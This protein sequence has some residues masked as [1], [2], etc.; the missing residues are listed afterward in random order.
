MRNRTGWLI[1]AVAALAGIALFAQSMQKKM[2]MN[3]MPYAKVKAAL[4]NPATRMKAVEMAKKNHVLLMGGR[5]VQGRPVAW[6]GELTGANCY[7]S[8]GMHGHHHALCAKACVVAGTPILFLHAG[9]TYLVLTPADG[10]PLPQGAYNDLGDPGVTVHGKVLHSH[11]IWAIA[12][13]SVTS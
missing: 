4:S 6:K 11:G 9:R 13:R 1:V 3:D 5:P 12:V 7:L 10:R 2:D 8:A